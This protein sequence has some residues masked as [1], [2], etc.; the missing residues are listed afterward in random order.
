MPLRRYQMP[1][2]VLQTSSACKLEPLAR[3]MVTGPGAGFA[4]L[5]VETGFELTRS[6]AESGRVLGVDFAILEVN[7]LAEEDVLS[8]GSTGESDSW[9]AS[10]ASA[11]NPFETRGA[12]W[13]TPE[14]CEA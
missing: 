6:R 10:A 8:S 9:C 7:C 3:R 14:S 2:F 13:D 11:E 1:A 12:T 5:P 4:T